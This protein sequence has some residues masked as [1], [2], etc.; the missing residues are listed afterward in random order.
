MANVVTLQPPHFNQEK[1]IELQ[2]L[3]DD[4]FW[5]PER[6]I[7]EMALQALMIYYEDFLN[8]V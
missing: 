2:D 5:M 4:D 1:T 3:S 6:D 8:A 7:F